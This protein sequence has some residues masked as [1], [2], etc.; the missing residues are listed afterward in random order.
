MIAKDGTQQVLFD[1]MY[2]KIARL[3]STRSIV[4][5]YGRMDLW[6]GGGAIL[7]HPLGSKPYSTCINT[8]SSKF[9]ARTVVN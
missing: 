5:A 2:R 1:L 3:M 9:K 7:Q 6:W 8:C 4:G